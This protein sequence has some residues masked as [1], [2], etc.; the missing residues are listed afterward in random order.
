VK[1][2]FQTLIALGHVHGVD[3]NIG[4]KLP[5][6][7]QQLECFALIENYVT[8][9][10]LGP[11]STK[12]KLLSRLEEWEGKALEAKLVTLEQ[13]QHW[14]KGLEQLSG[15]GPPRF[16]HAAEQTHVIAQKINA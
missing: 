2:Y 5:M 10:H 8:Q 16:F 13:L 6:L 14:K 9:E 1:D 15:E 3:F 7:C 11:K 4:N 12:E